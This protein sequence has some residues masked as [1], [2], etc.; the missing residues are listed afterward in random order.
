MGVRRA[1]QSWLRSRPMSGERSDPPCNS[2]WLPHIRTNA[3]WIS[4]SMPEVGQAVGVRE[5]TLAQAINEA[6]AEEMRRDPRVFIIGEDVAEAGTPFKGLSGLV[7]EF[8]RE[9][10]G[11]C[12]I[13]GPRAVPRRNTARACTPGSVTCR[14]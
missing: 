8:G 6:L 2:P 14:G 12:P 7:G 11:D 3:K 1:R 5:L 4:R 13:C 9:R 10:G